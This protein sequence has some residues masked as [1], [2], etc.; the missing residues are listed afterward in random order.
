MLK[1]VLGSRARLG[2][3]LGSG[4][5]SGVVPWYL[6]GGIS[7]AN[8]VAAYQPKGAASLAASYVNLVSPGTYDAAPGVAPTWAAGT[9]WTFNGSSQ[10]L[11]TG[12][13]PVGTTWSAFIQFSN[14]TSGGNRWLFGVLGGALAFGVVPALFSGFIQYYNGNSVL[15]SAAVASGNLGV[16]GLVGYLNGTSSGSITSGSPTYTQG[17]FI[18]AL[19]SAGT[20]QSYIACNVQAVAI[21]N[22]TLTPAQVAILAVAMAAL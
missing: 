14:R 20:P 19:N 1:G 22:S 11:A 4:R 18:G 16:A 5:G 15:G 9:G 3:P 2:G 13:I 10:Y 17:V 6:A 7:A 21:F 12:V 8:C